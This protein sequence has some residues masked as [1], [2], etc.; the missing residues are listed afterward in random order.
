M[1][2]PRT[3]HTWLVPLYNTLEGKVV[4]PLQLGSATGF[5]GFFGVSGIVR[6]AAF[7]STGGAVAGG[8]TGTTFFDMRS[9]G[10]TGTNYVTFNDVVLYMKRL[11]LLT[12]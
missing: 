4:R 2:I 11:G 8:P 5:I 6:P 12:P 3:T 1:S 7:G 10:G 9:N